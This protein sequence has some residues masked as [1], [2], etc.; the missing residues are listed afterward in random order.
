LAA[1][2]VIAVVMVVTLRGLW[3]GILSMLLNLFPTLLLFGSMGWMGVP[4]NIGYVMTAKVALG[5]AVD[6]T[7]HF[8]VCYRRETATAA[9]HRKP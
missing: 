3:A 6:D 9:T 7:L 1:F 4:V 5:I 2:S 8:L